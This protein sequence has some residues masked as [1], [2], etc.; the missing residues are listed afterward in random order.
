MPYIIGQELNQTGGV[1]LKINHMHD[2]RYS[3][4]HLRGLLD[5]I[6]DLPYSV[7]GLPVIELGSNTGDSTQMWSLIASIVYSVDPF[8]FDGNNGRT[9]EQVRKFFT[10]RMNGKHY[11]SIK[12]YSQDEANN[13]ALPE[14]AG[15]IYIDADHTYPFVKRD[16]SLYWPR[17]M[18]GGFICGHDYGISIAGQDGVKPAVDEIF[19]EPDKVYIDTSW[20]VQKTGGRKATFL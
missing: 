1:M 3:Y 20:I 5:L 4:D 17:V 16:I 11:I 7:Y 10:D 15:V 13:P 18:D 14:K 9:G 8:I 2:Y 12:G 6:M 19:G